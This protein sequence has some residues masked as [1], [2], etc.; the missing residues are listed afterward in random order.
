MTMRTKRDRGGGDGGDGDGDGGAK[1]ADKIAPEFAKL[2]HYLRRTRGFDFTNYKQ[3]GLARRFEKRMQMIGVA[4]YAAYTDYL[5]VHPEEFEQL[6]NTILINVTSFFRDPT[7]WDYLA[8]VIVPDVLSRRVG[9]EPVRVWCAGCASGEE[10]YSLAML[11]A[12]AMGREPFCQRV[13]IYAT[14]ADD[15]ALAQARQASYTATAVEGVGAERLEKYFQQVQDRYVFDPEL[16]R[17]VIF[18]RLDLFNDA[19]ISRVDLLS[20]RNTLMYFNAEAQSRILNRFHFALTEQG[21]LFLGKAEMLLTQGHLFTPVDV[22]RRLFTKV[23]GADGRERMATRAQ[24]PN[25]TDVEP[26]SAERVRQVALDAAPSA[27]LIV[28]AQGVI[29]SINERA[30]DLFGLTQRDVGRLLQDLEISFRPVELRSLVEQAFR[31]GRP[32]LAKE[33][34]WPQPQGSRMVMD[35]IVT[36]LP[37]HGD[38][39]GILITYVDVTRHRRLTEELR[40]AHEALEASQ[41]EL[42]STS[43][44]LET[45]NEELQ[46]TVEELETTN[47]E[48]QS[49][50]EQLETMNEELQSTNEEL[51]TTN[52]ELRLRSDELNSVNRFLEAILTSLR[53]GVIVLDQEL[54][55]TAWNERSQ[56]LWGLRPDEVKGQHFLN[57]DIGLPVAELKSSIRACVNGETEAKELVLSARN[58]RGRDIGCKVICTPLSADGSPVRG[59]ILLI[60]EIEQ[61]PGK[62]SK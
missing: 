57:L 15:N 59:T 36:P 38:V 54:R 27:Q 60:E 1:S 48:L 5:E 12:D 28:D 25:G 31:D 56:D 6:F 53:T 49:T 39:L 19:P 40:H 17:C 26:S 18:G 32:V 14:D 20:C 34:D 16:R 45:T 42:Q 41:E 22:R 44:E 62:S 4:D 50:N 55:I 29:A 33:V 21:Y 8:A 7:A 37:D 51:H 3:A 58:R 23:N 46:S 24:G 11:F 2:L 47:E 35:V 9:D 10:A 30:R 13:K 61:P 52:E 43:E